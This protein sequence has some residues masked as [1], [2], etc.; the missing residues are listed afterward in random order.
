MAGIWG[1]L[2]QGITN[3]L[4]LGGASLLAGEGMGGALQGMRV[5][6]GF[7]ED[8]RQQALRKQQ[9]QAFQGLLADPSLN[10]P[11]QVRQI[12]QAAG[13]SS[14]LEFLM[15]Q[16]DP[17]NGLERQYKEAQIAK[18]KREAANGGEQPSNVREWQY[19]Q[20]L[21]PEQKQQYLT[22]KR[23]EKWLDTGTQF[24]SPSPGNPQG[25]PRTVDKNVAEEQRLKQSGEAAGKAAADLPRAL[26]AGDR[27]M[28]QI[29]GVQS[30]PN[31]PNVTGWQGFLP[32]FNPRN[33]DTEERIAQLGG[34][35]FLQAFESLKGGGQI[36]EIEGKKATDAL[37]RLQNLRQSDA[38]FKQA[39][40]DF[41]GE[42]ESLMQL[43]R[44]RA[45]MA[46]A[47]LPPPPKKTPGWSI[48]RVD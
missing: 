17:A 5:G 14:G 19:F 41:K 20:S 46:P 43:A 9:E 10:L 6:Q 35:A 33:V 45:G 1:D 24:V 44:E 29:Q 32:T 31:L 3:P 21:S 36:T 23:A 34:G 8:R 38:G 12:A 22:M 30:D 26:A 15:K 7:Q 16:A 39:L 27:M 47:A 2:E 48:K 11:P 18:L 25:T 4:F 42:V 40:T 28:E 13:P 37:A